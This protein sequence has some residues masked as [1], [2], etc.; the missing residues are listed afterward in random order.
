L[1]NNFDIQSILKSPCGQLNQHLAE[2][3]E[4]KVRIK[5][6]N[7]CPEVSWIHWQLKYWCIEKEYT[8]DKEYRFSKRRFRFDFFIKELNCG[9]EYEGIFGER[10]RHTNKMGYS[11]DTEKYTLA[12]TIGILVLRYTAVNYKNVIRDLENVENHKA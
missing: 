10:S 6:R 3:P 7:D 9:I 4:K 11:K 1:R 8:L 2:K 12:A 5:P